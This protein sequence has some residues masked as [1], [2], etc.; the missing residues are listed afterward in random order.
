MKPLKTIK[1]I[2]RKSFIAVLLDLMQINWPTSALQL[3]SASKHYTE[4]G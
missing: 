1:T 4:R 3:P 2:M